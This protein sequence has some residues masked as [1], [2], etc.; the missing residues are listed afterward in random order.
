MSVEIRQRQIP[1]Q[2]ELENVHPVL[3]RIYAARGIQQSDEL[4]YSLN[5]LLPYQ[6]LKNID[7]AVELLANAI[8]ND[9]RILIVADFDADGATSCAVAIRSLSAMGAKQVQ[10]IVPNRFEFG[11]GLT[12]EIVDVASEYEPDL[13]ITVDNGISSIAGVNHAN[14]I[15]IDVLVT[16]HHLPGSELP[17]AATIVNPNQP[18]D[19]YPSKNLAG[20]GVIF[21]IMIALRAYLR[22]SGWFTQQS[23]QEFNLASVLDLVAL[24]TVADVVPLDYNNRLMV[25]QGLARIRSG[26]CCA[27]ILELLRVS[28]RSLNQV[29]SADLGFAIGPRLN[30]AGR[31]TDM[32]VGIECLLSD[33]VDQARAL[34]AQLNDL[35]LERRQ[36]QQDMESSALESL[37]EKLEFAEAAV[38]AGICLFDA[39]WHQGVVGI[40]ASRIKEKFHRPVIVFAP[41]NNGLIKGSGRSI[42]GVHIRD[43]L[44]AISTKHPG[45]I[46]KFGGHAMAAGLTLQEADFDQFKALFTEEILN[47]VD[48][49]QLNGIVLTDGQLESAD[50]NMSLANA[51][52]NG[53][54]WGQGFPEPVF[55]G[56]FGIVNRKIVGEKHLKLTLSSDNGALAA[57][58]FNMTDEDWSDEPDQV[59]ITYRL[60]VNEYN[61]RRSVQLCVEHIELDWMEENKIRD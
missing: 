18:G 37:N 10:Y 16:D 14:E 12:P 42:N 47:Q 15:G 6:Q 54:P 4:E 13:I 33:D 60:D 57:I 40:L 1:D 45:L 46:P 22:D 8:K 19:T 24:G 9:Q 26:Q 7:V 2:V 31:L 21:N 58:A 23:L 38:P 28:N 44:E 32:S 17:N 39:N 55:T 20:V 61:G 48:E 29:S 30:A 27:G 43:V 35:N 52:R 25:S 50:I 56:T 51:I 34:A 36:I 49:C 41:D 11:Y 53:G 59:S 5:R 3:A